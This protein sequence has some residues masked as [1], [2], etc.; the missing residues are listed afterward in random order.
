[1]STREDINDI[2]KPMYGRV[3]MGHLMDIGVLLTKY[4]NN[5][6][7]ATLD[8]L[9]DNMPMAVLFDAHGASGVLTKDDGTVPTYE[10]L[11]TFIMNKNQ[12]IGLWL[13]RVG[14]GMGK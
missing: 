1:M 2:L 4:K 11:K 8:K 10:E 9:I 12:I 5:P 13:K 6:N 7:M 14:E 3:S